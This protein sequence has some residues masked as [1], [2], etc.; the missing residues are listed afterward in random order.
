MA[1]RSCRF[2]RCHEIQDTCI[3]NDILLSN[4]HQSALLG[5]PWC[6]LLFDGIHFFS[7]R[8][9]HLTNTER[10]QVHLRI[11]RGLTN[12]N[13]Q[14]YLRWPS[15]RQTDPL[16]ECFEGDSTDYDHVGIEFVFEQN[17]P[18]V[19]DNSAPRLDVG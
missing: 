8:W 17:A 13:A 5:C 9:S 11:E 2:C 10:S 6:K 19:V 1:L 16:L 3:S 14:L 18:L 7:H 4:V 12:S 15:R